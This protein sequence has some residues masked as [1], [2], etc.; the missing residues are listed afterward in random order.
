MGI[1]QQGLKGWASAKGAGRG[2]ERGSPCTGQQVAEAAVKEQGTLR[3]IAQ[4]R[5]TLCVE[6]A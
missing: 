1:G 6:R 4:R 3:G 5:G 2:Q